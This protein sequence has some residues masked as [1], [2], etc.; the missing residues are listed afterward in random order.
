MLRLS[1]EPSSRSHPARIKITPLRQH[2]E[3]RQLE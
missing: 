2:G 3:P 1:P